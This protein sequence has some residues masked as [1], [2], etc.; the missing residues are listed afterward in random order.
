[1]TSF[2]KVAFSFLTAAVLFTGFV[3][4]AQAKLIDAIETRFFAK[5]KIAENQQQ[6]D[7]IAK[8]CDSYIQNILSS[9]ENGENAYLNSPDI[10]SYV[11]LNPSEK[12]EASR[13]L[14][15][16]QILT[17]FPAIEGLRLLEK[18]GRNINFSTIES[19]ILETNGLI[20][21][22]KNY[23]DLKED[24]TYFDESLILT[25]EFNPTRKILF[26]SQNNRITI[27]FPF[28]KN[29]DTYFGA[30]LCYLNVRSIENLLYDNHSLSLGTSLSLVASKDYLTGGFVAGIPFDNTQAFNDAI[31]KKWNSSSLK[32]GQPD[33][34]LASE[35]GTIWVMLPVTGV[36]NIKFGGVYKNSSFELSQEAVW[37]IYICVFITILLVAYLLFSLKRDYMTVVK[38]RIKKVQFGIINEYL[39]N[40]EEV[41]WESVAKQ[42]EFRK[43]EFC[44]EIK[45]S[46]GGNS[47]NHTKEIDAFLDSS[48]DEIISVI[49]ASSKKASVQNNS[50]ASIEEIRAVLEDVLKTV[51]LTVNAVQTVQTVPGEKAEKKSASVVTVEEVEEATEIEEVEEAEAL[52]EV[53]EVEEADELEDAEPVEEIEEVEDAEDLEEAEEVEDAENVEEIEDA[54][55]IDD[56]EDLDE[57]E[58]IE[59]AEDLEET[60]GVDEAE[61]IEDAEPVEEIE[62]AEEVESAEEIEEAEEIDDEEKLEEAEALEEADELEEAEEVENAEDVADSEPLDEVET[63][64]ELEDLSE[65][66]EVSESEASV[67][68]VFM[69]IPPIPVSTGDIYEDCI[70]SYGLKN[71]TFATVETVF[72]EQLCIGEEYTPERKK[73]N[74]DIT[75]SAYKPTFFGETEQIDEL[76]PLNENSAFAMTQFASNQNQA[77]IAELEEETTEAIVEENGVYTISD[78][79]AFTDL[80]VNPD[81]KNLVDSV[82]K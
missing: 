42:L 27:S 31:V 49:K 34:I 68:D 66:E 30:F 47:K 48:W 50:G 60:D 6:L 24:S 51:K 18:N 29:D 57:A 33:R 67:S 16:N 78:S 43:Q 10:R 13:R 22:Y 35:D 17:Q 7:E 61:E 70:D 46:V 45:K 36:K 75:F 52:E 3:F 9:F 12:V 41:E 71:D 59:D 56:T 54:E 19:D 39:Q 2:Q 25:D 14:L 55:E 72:G 11:Y 26:D 80:A 23:P 81:L 53:E 38:S 74:Y 37:V 69:Y 1:M 40:K 76:I 32:D 8:A 15:T 4:V 62:N 65:L 79:L 77:E 5:S 82:L 58:E 28:Y 73:F 21:K 44:E 63:A 20:R 64:E